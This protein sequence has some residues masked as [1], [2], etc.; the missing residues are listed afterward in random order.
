[1]TTNQAQDAESAFDRDKENEKKEEPD[2]FER[3]LRFLSQQSILVA[4][5]EGRESWITVK[6]THLTA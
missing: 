2:V 4:A 1:M 5:D 3:R 6:F